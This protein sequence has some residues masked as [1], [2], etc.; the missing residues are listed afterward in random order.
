M[1]RLKGGTHVAGNLTVEGIITTG[2]LNH[3]NDGSIIFTKD[4]TPLTPGAIPRVYSADQL[5]DSN[6]TDDGTNVDITATTTTLTGALVAASALIYGD[7]NVAT[8]ILEEGGSTTSDSYL[9]LKCA[10]TSIADSTTKI[11]TFDVVNEDRTLTISVDLTL[12]QSVG[13][14]D[15]VAFA[16]AVIAG[17]A[18]VATVIL[19]DDDGV[20][21][22]NLLKIQSNSGITGDTTKTLTLD[23]NNADRI[24]SL[25]ADIEL[26]QSLLTTSS[27]TFNHLTIASSTLVSNLN[28]EH[29]NGAAMTEGTA[30]PTGAADDGDIYF[31]RA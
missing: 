2:G 17:N 13:T 21:P 12:D 28:A 24:L 7:A 22:D 16:S 20:D 18:Q 23:V 5:E 31:Q 8:V 27:P 26:N 19:E 14:T 9:Q 25:A 29:W 3:D 6:I 30:V 11:L 1:A 10:A 15:N 4:A